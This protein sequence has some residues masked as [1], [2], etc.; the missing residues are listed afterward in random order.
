MHRR[1]LLL[2]A[3]LGLAAAFAANAQLRRNFPADSLRGRLAIEHPPL[4][5]LNGAQAR[6]APG[7]RI[8]GQNNMLA[9]TGAFAGQS[10]IV[11][12][13]IDMQGQIKDIWVLTDE[14]IGRLWPVTREQAASWQF[15]PGTQTWAKP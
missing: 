6:L 3:T 9:T 7:A 15:D 1:N 5:V 12:Y 11:N 4:A 14:E 10:F 2:L 8:R 13:T